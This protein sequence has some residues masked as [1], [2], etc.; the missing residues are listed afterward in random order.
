MSAK[1]QDLL[2]QYNLLLPDNLHNSS[3]DLHNSLDNQHSSNLGLYNSLDNLH[4]SIRDLCNSLDNLHNSNL[5][6]YSSALDNNKISS[7]YLHNNVQSNNSLM[8]ILGL[9]SQ[10]NRNPTPNVPVL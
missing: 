3:L 2:L 5:G 10:L 6:L 1:E 9:L 4:N 8:E 7:P